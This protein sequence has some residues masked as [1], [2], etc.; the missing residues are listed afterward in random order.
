MDGIKH[1]K[2]NGTILLHE[3]TVAGE[4]TVSMMGIEAG[5]LLKG[6]YEVFENDGESLNVQLSPAGIAYKR[7]NSTDW[8]AARHRDEKELGSE[9]TMTEDEYSALL[10]KRKNWR[11]LL[12]PT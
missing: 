3:S 5:L 6:Y 10:E 9:T 1:Y 4:D 8:R 2:H 12:N 11:T 7:L